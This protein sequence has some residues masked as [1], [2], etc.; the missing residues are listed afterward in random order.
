MTNTL[1]DTFKKF[2]VSLNSNEKEDYEVEEFSIDLSELEN[3]C[4]IKDEGH[5]FS[6]L[7][8]DRERFDV[9]I[10][11][12]DSFIRFLILNDIECDSELSQNQ[13]NKYM[14]VNKQ[15]EKSK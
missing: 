5:F 7:S 6:V 15:H 13:L 3:P 14:E 8:K 9:P 2:H 1:F 4:H 12:Y 11:F 10:R